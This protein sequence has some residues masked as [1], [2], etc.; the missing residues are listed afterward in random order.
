M[1]AAFIVLLFF[2]TA[3]SSALAQQE[4]QALTGLLVDPTCSGTR[5]KYTRVSIEAWFERPVELECV[6]PSSEAGQ[7]WI[8]ETYVDRLPLVLMNSEVETSPAFENLFERNWL[9]R[10]QDGSKTLYQIS[11]SALAIA[12]GYFFL[13]RERI[14][15]RLDIFAMTTC[16][17]VTIAR[18]KINHYLDLYPNAGFETIERYL[19]TDMPALGGVISPFG[20]ED[21]EE[22]A[23][24]VIIQKDHPEKFEEYL[25][26]RED[27]SAE[28]AA[29]A[30]G[31]NIESID[32]GRDRAMERL[33]EDA[34]LV[35]RFKITSSPVFLWENQYLIYGLQGLARQDV[36]SGL[37]VEQRAV[38]QC[39]ETGWDPL[40]PER[41]K[42]GC[43]TCGS[44]APPSP[45][46]RPQF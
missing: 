44:C 31:L 41:S 13:N 16:P 2:L 29:D 42:G 28:E 37:L 9:T 25:R 43:G 8:T 40:S 14:P 39:D 27:K 12:P 1:R 15:G 19:V 20:P 33:K 11:K 46:G 10:Y 21:L 17:Y 23:R 5:I 38:G 35:D 34:E 4:T 18:E 22:A 6:T 32:A 24:R 45:A 30:A 3:G 26:F 36:W 7:K